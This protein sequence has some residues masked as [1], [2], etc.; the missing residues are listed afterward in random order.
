MMEDRNDFGD[1]V[2]P[3][4]DIIPRNVTIKSEDLDTELS[5][6]E[7]L[8]QSDSKIY[9]EYI[10]V[11]GFN[12]VKYCLVHRNYEDVPDYATGDIDKSIDRNVKIYR[13]LPQPLYKT[14]EFQNHSWGYKS[15]RYTAMKAYGG[16]LVPHTDSARQINF[17]GF[18]VG[19]D[20]K[21]INGLWFNDGPYRLHNWPIPTPYT[22]YIVC[23]IMSTGPASFQG[24]IGGGSIPLDQN[25]GYTTNNRLYF[26]GRGNNVA[27]RARYKP[28][29]RFLFTFHND[30]TTGWYR[31]N[32]NAKIILRPSSGMRGLTNIG[33]GKQ[34]GTTNPTMYLGDVV[35]YDIYFIE[36]VMT[37][38][39]DTIMR[40]YLD[41]LW[42]FGPVKPFFDK[43]II[44]RMNEYTS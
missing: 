16:D 30:N 31:Q 19:R 25:F 37:E 42:D 1:I 10:S 34:G 40:M 4:I 12:F 26:Y 21:R 11:L 38:A 33:I 23:K 20:E 35:I 44:N 5:S 14:M 36:G 3:D 29:E 2:Q 43:G 28:G 32:N 17:D 15:S 41:G 27:M 13:I 24:I 9:Q 18:S 7:F 22:M 8:Q 6:L 39:Q